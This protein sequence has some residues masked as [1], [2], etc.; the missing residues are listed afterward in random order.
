MK[1]SVDSES[2]V[3]GPSGERHSQQYSLAQILGIWAAAA[4][5]MGGARE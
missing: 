5:L 3:Q 1:M 2:R 4:L